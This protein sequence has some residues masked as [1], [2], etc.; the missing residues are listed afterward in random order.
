MLIV[1]R[2]VHKIKMEERK[3]IL[4]LRK[5]GWKEREGE[6]EYRVGIKSEKEIRG[7]K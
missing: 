3:K 6:R 1:W 2:N 5:R 7:W 4:R